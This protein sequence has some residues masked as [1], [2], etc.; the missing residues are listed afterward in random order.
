MPKNC[1]LILSCW[2]LWAQSY[3]IVIMQ[4]PCQWESR[5]HVTLSSQMAWPLIL[6]GDIKLTNGRMF[7]LKMISRNAT[8]LISNNVGSASIKRSLYY[9]ILWHCSKK[10]HLRWEIDFLLIMSRN[11]CDQW[12]LVVNFSGSFTELVI[13]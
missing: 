8:R 9:I 13:W 1:S 10:L 12:V 3:N 4:I 6:F 5:W 11:P 7:V 2:A